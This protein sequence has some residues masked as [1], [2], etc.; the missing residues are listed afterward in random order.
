MKSKFTSFVIFAGMRTGSN[1]LEESLNEYA[2]IKCYGEAF[3]PH[4]TGKANSTEL[5][6]IGLAERETNPLELIERMKS[7]D[8]N[9]PGFRFF[10]DH[11][12]RVF[13][14]CIQDK[15]CAK[16]ILSRN[17]VDSYVSREIARA[18]GQWRLGDPTKAKSAKIEF[19]QVQFQAHLDD[20]LAFQSDIQSRLQTSGQTAFQVSY[21]DL[22]DVEKLNGLA[23]F[24]GATERRDEVTK[25][26]KKQNP[27]TLEDKVTNYAEMVSALT[28][29]D[30]FGMHAT[31]GFEPRRG[32][33]VTSYVAAVSAPLLFMPIRSGPYDSVLRWLSGFGEGGNEGILRDFTQ[34]KLRHWKR[35]TKDHR[36]FT[37][38]RHPVA[39]LFDAY[40]RHILSSSG[41]QH[42]GK[43]RETLV[44]SYGLGDDQQLT[45]ATAEQTRNDFLAFAAA[46]K[47]NLAGQTSFRV[48]A[49]WCSQAELVRGM[50]DVSSPDYIYREATLAHELQNLTDLLGLPQNAYSDEESCALDKALAAIYDDNVEAAVRAAYQ[51]DY[52]MFGFGPWVPSGD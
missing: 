4:F 1:F 49:S 24:L 13:D 3:N 32:P 17:P 47:L 7:A 10:H 40:Q 51:K 5:L 33:A 29:H 30:Y 44:R 21:D 8:E 20:Q 9:L 38:V 28:G 22:A 31:P 6:G 25:K 12:H 26:T 37:V 39:R 34:K 50:A 14:H 18:T 35:N 11:D 41:P 52:M 19:D 27:S 15:A 36:S 23:K 45:D 2:G 42:F 43:I 46:I 16:I 48:D